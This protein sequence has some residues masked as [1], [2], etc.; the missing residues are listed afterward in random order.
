MRKNIGLRLS[1][2]LVALG[3]GATPVLAGAQVEWTCPGLMDS[4]VKPL[5]YLMHCRPHSL[6]D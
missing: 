2:Y 3:L 4:S 6:R 5:S 1:T